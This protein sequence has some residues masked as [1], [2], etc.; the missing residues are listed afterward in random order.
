MKKILMLILLALITMGVAFAEPSASS[1]DEVCQTYGYDFGI[2][3]WEWSTSQEGY[4]LV[5]EPVTAGTSVTGDS[6]V[7][8]WTSEISVAGVL[9]NE[10]CTFQVTLGGTSGSV[11]RY[12]PL[13]NIQEVY[14]CGDYSDEEVPEF[15]TIAAS[16]A[17]IGAVAGFIIMRKRK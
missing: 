4:V 7:A 14:F 6:S 17:L 13:Y 10:I 16:I 3:Q 12:D 8:T 9:T 1:I 15:G 2:A 5:E 11:E